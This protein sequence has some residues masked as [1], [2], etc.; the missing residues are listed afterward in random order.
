[1]KALR[2]ILIASCVA[3]ACFAPAAHA[4]KFFGGSSI[5]ILHSADYQG[6][7]FDAGALPRHRTQ[8]EIR[9]TLLEPVATVS[10]AV[11]QRV[12]DFSTWGSTSHFSAAGSRQEQ[13]DLPLSSVPRFPLRNPSAKTTE[14]SGRAGE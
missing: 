6:V 4:E 10:H 3:A 7:Q 5:S 12:L 14:R 8:G 9:V 13:E 1:M 2:K 11:C